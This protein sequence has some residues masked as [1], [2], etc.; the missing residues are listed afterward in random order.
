MDC[1][2]VN[3]PHSRN[4]K[5]AEKYIIYVFTVNVCVCVER[6]YGF[7]CIYNYFFIVRTYKVCLLICFKTEMCCVS[8]MKL[9]RDGVNVPFMHNMMILCAARF[10]F[11]LKINYLS[12]RAMECGYFLFVFFSSHS[13]LM[14]H[15]IMYK[16]LWRDRYIYLYRLL[17]FSREFR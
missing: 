15:N 7:F 12:A 1:P 16:L 5:I 6:N 4:I 17:L 8:C 3:N 9:N 14:I 2:R 13:L 11:A 10:I